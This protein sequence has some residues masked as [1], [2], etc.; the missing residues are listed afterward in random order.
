[1]SVRID[2]GL[3]HALSIGGFEIHHYGEDSGMGILQ[4]LY[5]V[6]PERGVTVDIL[7]HN[8]NEV[9]ETSIAQGHQRFD[10]VE[11]HH[12]VVKTPNGEAIKG[13]LE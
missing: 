13:V 10:D 3:R 5:I 12:T 9:V 11:L 6:M 8:Q 1:M 2:E 7:F 4:R